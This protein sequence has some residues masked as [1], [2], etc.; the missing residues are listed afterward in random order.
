[1]DKQIIDLAWIDP[2]YT[3]SL[4]WEE[5]KANEDK[6]CGYYDCRRIIKAGEHYYVEITEQPEDGYCLDCASGWMAQK[7]ASIIPLAEALKEST[8]AT[9]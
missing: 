8:S 2:V 7:L 6:P 9:D 3:A 5:H 1:M 4:K